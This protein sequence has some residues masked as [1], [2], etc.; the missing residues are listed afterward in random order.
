M[1]NLKILS[2]SWFICINT[3]NGTGM[4]NVEKYKNRDSN[5]TK[6]N[7]KIKNYFCY[8]VYGSFDHSFGIQNI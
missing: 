5:E 2:E 6:K 4:E 7:K 3:H 8:C 1:L